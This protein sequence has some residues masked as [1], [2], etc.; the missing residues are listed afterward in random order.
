M[1]KSIHS[2]KEQKMPKRIMIG[3][4]LLLLSYV[5][6]VSGDMGR[7]ITYDADVREDSQK[8]IILHNLEEEVLIL[9]TDLVSDRRTTLL[10]FIPFPTEPK[11][12]LAEGDP[13]DLASKL[14][15][16]HKLDERLYKGF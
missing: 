2:H 8:A 13:F 5:P 15:R 9:G 10:R 1:G 4:L 14:V 11:V 12:S 7:I 16:R 3:A 6:P